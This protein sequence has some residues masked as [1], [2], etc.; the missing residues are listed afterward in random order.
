MVTLLAVACAAPQ[1]AALPDLPPGDPARPDIV[2]VSIDSLRA[3]HLGAWGA[4]RPTSPFLDRLAASGLRFSDARTLSPWTLP[5]HTTMLSGQPP[6]AHGVVEDTV[7]VSRDLP[8]LPER[9]RDAGWAT[10]GFV[11]SVYVSRRF[12]FDRGFSRFLDYEVDASTNLTH[13]TSADR[14]V[15]DA[16]RWAAEVGEGTP[17]FLFLHL[18]DAHYPYRCPEPYAS[19]F[20]R[21][22]TPT[23]T[24]YRS[25]AW[26]AEHPPTVAEMAHNVA[27]YDECVAWVDHHLERL[28]AAWARSGRNA[29]WLVTA[30]HG[31][32][33][34]ERGSWGHGHTLWRE[35]VHVPMILV[36]PGVSPAVRTEPV[37][38][39]DVAP[40]L[41]AVAGL[42]PATALGAAGSDL[43]DTIPPRAF[44]AETARHDTARLSYEAEGWR[45]DVDV[46]KRVTRLYDRATD[47]AERAD[48]AGAEPDRV[49]RMTRSL[50]EAMGEPW[51]AEGGTVLTTASAYRRGAWVGSRFGGDGSF[52]VWPPDVLVR[53]IGPSAAGP[54]PIDAEGAAAAPSHGP[55]RWTGPRWASP[56]QLDDATR[57]RLE[58][59]GYAQ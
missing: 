29:A 59:L 56:V 4:A 58:A 27:Q 54:G 23:S 24:A 22:G 49:S 11:S 14:Q 37:A 2:L 1:E 3:D 45:L 41:A 15:E 6:V 50:L 51:V 12:G 25:Y 17:L 19:R 47:P 43:R 44:V 38:T 53:R 21:A 20:D 46:P 13:V 36:A 30:D 32:E 52:G 48:R 57:E 8:W 16:A 9:L 35:V 7:G 39:I 10:G 18:Y 26:H 28:H 40:T 42:D 33:L 34:L 55:L 31:E 5:A